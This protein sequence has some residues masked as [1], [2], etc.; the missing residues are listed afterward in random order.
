M[1]E[2]YAPL[3]KRAMAAADREACGRSLLYDRFDE[4]ASNLA[5]LLRRSSS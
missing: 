4:L 5:A 3:M 1:D 2:L